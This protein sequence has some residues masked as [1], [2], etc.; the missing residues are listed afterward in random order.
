MLHIGQLP[1]VFPST[2]QM[3]EG[4]VFYCACKNLIDLKLKLNHELIEVTEWMKST[5]LALSIVKT[6]FIL[7]HSKRQKPYKT[8]NLKINEV[9]IQQVSTVKYL[10]VTFDANLTWK[11]PL[12][13]F[14]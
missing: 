1:P 12:M 9:N 8:F 5:Q 7:F 13:S 10:G 14:V 6:S 2:V 4:N 11:S 3:M